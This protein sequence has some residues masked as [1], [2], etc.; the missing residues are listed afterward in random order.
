MR[1]RRFLKYVLV[2]LGLAALALAAWIYWAESRPEAEREWRIQVQAR[3][4]AMFPEAM[5]P[6]PGVYGWRPHQESADARLAV[7]LVHG[8]DEPGD[9]WA[10][11]IAAFAEAP[12]EV[13]EFRYPNDQAIDASADFL[14]EQWADLDS[15]REVIFIAHSM[16]G[17]VVRDFVTRHYAPGGERSLSVGPAVRAAWLVATPNHGSEWARLRVWLELRD[18]FTSAADQEFALFSALR[19]GTGAAKVDLRPGS[20]FLQDLNERTWPDAVDLKLI[21]GVFLDREQ[22]NQ[23]LDELVQ[24]APNEDLAAA[25]ATLGAD[26]RKATGDGVVTVESVALEGFPPP[27][28]LAASHRGL[29]RTSPLES[30]TPPALPILLDWLQAEFRTSNIEL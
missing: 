30:G 26:L 14:A 9:I 12:V 3:L 5:T 21:A 20:R 28:V 6:P 10:D 27:V 15:G 22:V 24:R 2:S 23:G 29:I 13:I 18:H 7:V 17:L 4:E 19:D 11:A 1:L 25:F 16:G 8:L